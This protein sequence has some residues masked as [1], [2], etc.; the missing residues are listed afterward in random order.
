M[1]GVD[2]PKS[3]KLKDKTFVF[4]GVLKDFTRDEAQR[5][6]ESLG[7]HA[8]SSVSKN[9]DFVVIGSDPGSKVE[10]PYGFRYVICLSPLD[11][12][13]HKGKKPPVGTVSIGV[14]DFYL[15]N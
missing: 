7:G 2:S 8:T 9:T 3:N 1:K 13:P 15:V 6:V 5:I 4:T 11:V 12:Y 14:I 10:T